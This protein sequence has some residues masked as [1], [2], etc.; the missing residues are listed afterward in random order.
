MIGDELKT[1][2]GFALLWTLGMLFFAW[3]VTAVMRD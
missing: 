2:T 1:S 3:V